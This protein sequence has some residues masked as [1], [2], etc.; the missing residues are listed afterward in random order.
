M[1]PFWEGLGEGFGRVLG[2]KNGKTSVQEGSENKA[3]KEAE[4]NTKIL[5]KGRELA[6]ERWAPGREDLGPELAL[7]FS[8]PLHPS[9]GRGRRIA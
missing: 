2:V 1:E 6:A 3:E 5:P 9:A 7:K 4:K 8:T